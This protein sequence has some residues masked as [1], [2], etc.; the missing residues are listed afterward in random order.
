MDDWR[1]ED[2]R[3]TR[4]IGTADVINPTAGNKRSENLTSGFL[5]YEKDAAPF[6]LYSGI[7]HSERFPDYWELIGKESMNSI[8][9]FNVEPEKTTQVDIG[10]VYRKHQLKDRGGVQST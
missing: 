3:E 4:T 1:A 8:S 9:A 2:S 6:T 5:R 7:G 10:A